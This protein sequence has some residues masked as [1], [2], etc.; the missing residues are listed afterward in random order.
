[1]DGPP[2]N[3]PGDLHRSGVVGLPDLFPP[4]LL[5]FRGACIPSSRHS[6]LLVVE[7]PAPQPLARP[8][9]CLQD[10]NSDYYAGSA[11]SFNGKKKELDQEATFFSARY[12]PDKV[13][14]DIDV[15][16]QEPH[17]RFS[18]CDLWR[19]GRKRMRTLF[20]V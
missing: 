11:K 10:R 9:T 6:F 4:L 17:F 3:P 20:S 19:S 13:A 7:P 8:G 5:I 14:L 12:P 1:V 18:P 15:V 16:E 2:K